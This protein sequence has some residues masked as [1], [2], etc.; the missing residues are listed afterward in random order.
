M[1]VDCRPA[2]RRF[3]EPPSTVLASPESLARMEFG[4]SDT[5]HVSTIDVRYCFYCI[6]IPQHVAAYFALP[7]LD[8]SLVDYCKGN[9]EGLVW[10]CVAALPMGFAWSLWFA[11]EINRAQVLSAGMPA[12]SELNA[13]AGIVVLR[14]IRSV[15]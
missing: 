12:E 9:F 1:I 13:H 11:H 15:L 10:P 3:K 7:P 6:R 14:N 4:E 2:N 5:L 8:A